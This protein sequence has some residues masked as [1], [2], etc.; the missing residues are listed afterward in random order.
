[1]LIVR[2]TGL[3]KIAKPAAGTRMISNFFNNHS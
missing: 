1:M 2:P 3:F